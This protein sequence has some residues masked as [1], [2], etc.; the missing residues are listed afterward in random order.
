MHLRAKI[1][2]GLTVINDTID[3]R[4]K[5][6]IH[7][8]TEFLLPPKVKRQVRIQVGENNARKQSRAHAFEQ[9]RN[10]FG[11]NLFAPGMA[12]V[13]MGADPGFQ[14]IL[15]CLAISFDNDRAT[16]VVL[17]NSRHQLCIRV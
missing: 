5:L 8:F 7:R 11:A 12:N 14:V 16:R 9:E 1:I 17:S 4:P 13:A 3:P 15:F 2:P 10:L 6:R